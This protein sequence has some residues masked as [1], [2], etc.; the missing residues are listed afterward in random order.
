MGS[1]SKELMSGVNDLVSKGTT[2]AE[3]TAKLASAA[4]IEPDTVNEILA[5]SIMCPPMDRLEGFARA[6]GV[7]VDSLV[8]AAKRDGCR[9]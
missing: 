8:M 1:L 5:G 9:Y 7:S 6:L 2:R 3:A 4:G